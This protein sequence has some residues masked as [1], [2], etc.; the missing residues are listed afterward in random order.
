MDNT[1]AVILAA[2]IAGFLG[3]DFFVQDW[4]WTLFLL[5]K[6]QELIDWAAFW[7]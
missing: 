3:Y 7:R 1:T 6:G 2:L 5:L 4:S